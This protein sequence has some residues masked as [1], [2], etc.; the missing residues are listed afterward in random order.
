MTEINSS[1]DTV[2]PFKLIKDSNGKTN[3]DMHHISRSVHAALEYYRIGTETGVNANRDEI[4]MG[5]GIIQCSMF[6]VSLRPGMRPK[7]T[8]SS[9]GYTLSREA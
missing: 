1:E 3:A 5:K 9:T 2:I 8:S 4:E 7:R 6:N